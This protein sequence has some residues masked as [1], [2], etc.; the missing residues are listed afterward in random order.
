MQAEKLHVNDQLKI[1]REL[2]NK[3]LSFTSEEVKVILMR[4]NC[5]RE[6]L[7]IVNC[8]VSKNIL[9]KFILVKNNLGFVSLV[10][11]SGR[12]RPA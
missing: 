1:F 4:D 5:R 9:D 3:K 10:D 2:H 11:Y 8:C 6:N 12:K 7:Q